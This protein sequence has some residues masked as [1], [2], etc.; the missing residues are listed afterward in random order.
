MLRKSLFALLLVSAACSDGFA[1]CSGD[2][3]VVA[4]AVNAPAASEV[5]AAVPGA[6][7]APAQPAASKG[8]VTGTIKFEGTA[9]ERPP[10]DF[11]PDPKCAEHHKDAPMPTPGGIEVG[12]GGGLKDVF[13]QLTTGLPD[14]KY[15]APTTPV[16]LDQ[17][18]CTY[19]PHVFGVMKKQP[20]TVKNSD[21][22]L[23]N[24][25]PT[26]KS[27]K[28][29]NI[30]M[31]EQNTEREL[32][33]KKAEEAIHIKCDVHPWMSA[34]CF[35]M[36]HPF[37]AVT[38]ADGTFSV[39]LGELADGEY[40]IKAWHETLGAQEGKVTVKDGAGTFDLAFKR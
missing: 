35:S 34:W 21:P 33:F 16:V 6:A 39:D 37:F 11:S 26:P 32:E 20:I 22:T 8:A 23:H 2:S 12:A 25:H 1:A 10:V 28:E 24:I 31:P 5:P 18:G 9:P 19:V 14:Q 13:V 3:D 15:E 30:A 36:E 7:A 29:S 27:N 38:G 17:V 4:P 40:G